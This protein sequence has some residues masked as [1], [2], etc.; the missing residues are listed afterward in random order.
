MKLRKIQI[1]RKLVRLGLRFWLGLNRNKNK[2]NY[3]RFIM[4]TITA[5]MKMIKMIN[6][7]KSYLSISRSSHK[8]WN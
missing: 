1:K 2:S 7:V 4:I 3:V 5:R 6:L 8:I